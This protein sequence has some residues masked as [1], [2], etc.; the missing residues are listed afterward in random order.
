MALPMWT[1]AG[2]QS[3]GSIAHPDV[4]QAAVVGVPHARW[5]EQVAAA[6]VML[7]GHNLEAV[8]LVEFCRDHLAGYKIPRTF[9]F[10]EELPVSA[11]GKV[12]KVEL[13]RSLQQET[14]Q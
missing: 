3:G 9:L 8:E 6:V 5:G 12:D 10:V 1:R 7:P 2:D 14:P 4:S 13:R 11:S